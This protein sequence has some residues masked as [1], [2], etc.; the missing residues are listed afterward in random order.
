[1]WLDTITVETCWPV[2]A[3]S[4]LHGPR[5]GHDLC[6]PA[7]PVYYGPKFAGRLLDQWAHLNGLEIDFSRP[8]KPSARRLTGLSKSLSVICGKG[9]LLQ[10]RAACRAGRRQSALA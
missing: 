8:G 7:I 6:R 4:G 1:L 9:W 5:G 10:W 2:V 3:D